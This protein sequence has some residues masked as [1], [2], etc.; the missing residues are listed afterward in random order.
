MATHRSNIMDNETYNKLEAE[1]VQ[2]EKKRHIEEL[3]KLYAHTTGA[4]HSDPEE[5][6]SRLEVLEKQASRHSEHL[7]NGTKYI[8][9]HE[10]KLEK[11]I[12][13]KVKDLFG[14]KLPINFGINHDPRGCALK[15][16]PPVNDRGL[17]TGE[18]SPFKLR[19][20]WGN[21]QLLA[22]DFA[23]ERR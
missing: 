19:R 22:P 7:C 9:W 18:A 11:E 14:G 1:R 17:D 15:L 3:G 16:F 13:D 20:D 8:G 21:N 5:L 6:F 10:A 2:K 4:E 23:Y 12:P